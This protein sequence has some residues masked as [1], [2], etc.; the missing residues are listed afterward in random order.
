M[1]SFHQSR[2]GVL[3]SRR[4]NGREEQQLGMNSPPLAFQ[5]DKARKEQDQELYAKA[6]S[7]AFKWSPQNNDN[8]EQAVRDFF[9]QRTDY[10]ASPGKKKKPHRISTK[11]KPSLSPSGSP[12]RLSPIPSSLGSAGSRGGSALRSPSMGGPNRSASSQFVDGLSPDDVGIRQIAQLAR[13]MNSPVRTEGIQEATNM[14]LRAAQGT[15]KVRL[16]AL[17]DV[18]ASESSSLTAAVSMVWCSRSSLRG[19]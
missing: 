3:I 4:Q 18:W 15:L 11:M 6:A 17:L 16:W 9:Q 13:Q 14:C 12:V 7:M 1:V 2:T 5:V 10:Y 19:W 8:P